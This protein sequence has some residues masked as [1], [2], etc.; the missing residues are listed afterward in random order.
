MLNHPIK[1]K[2]PL[3]VLQQVYSI[4]IEISQISI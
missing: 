2:Y 1:I 3:N 4:I